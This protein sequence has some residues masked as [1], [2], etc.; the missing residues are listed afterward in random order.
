MAAWGLLELVMHGE[1]WVLSSVSQHWLL[2][3]IQ[4]DSGRDG[5]ATNNCSF[6]YLI[7][8]LQRAFSA[9]LSSS[10]TIQE[11]AFMWC[12]WCL[13]GWKDL[14]KI[15]SLTSG[16][17]NLSEGGCVQGIWEALQKQWV[18][19]CAVFEC[20]HELCQLC[21]CTE[22][23]SWDTVRVCLAPE[24]S[25]CADISKLVLPSHFLLAFLASLGFF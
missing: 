4:R 25:E 8:A 12:I 19:L 9:F 1:H 3:K 18:L 6:V 15:P 14:L 17:K 7:Q 24:A 10:V 21:L 20:L 2:S 13:V 5:V 11:S 23:A 16:L 22:S